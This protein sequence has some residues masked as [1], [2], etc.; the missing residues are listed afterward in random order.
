MSAFEKGAGVSPGGVDLDDILAQMM[1]GMGGMGHGVPPGFGGRKPSKPRKGKD[2]EQSYPV[3]LEDLYNG[4]TVKFASTKNVICTHCKGSGGK[5]KAKPK[6]CSSC[7]GQ[8]QCFGLQRVL[9]DQ[10]AEYVQA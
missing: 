9:S 8:G 5:T 3:S 4:K 7:R 1:G 2:E 10:R 6:Q